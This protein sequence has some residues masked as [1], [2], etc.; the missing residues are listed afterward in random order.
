MYYS[1]DDQVSNLAVPLHSWS[2]EESRWGGQCLLFFWF[3]LDA[4]YLENRYVWIESKL[5]L[6]KCSVGGDLNVINWSV[7]LQERPCLE[8]WCQAGNSRNPSTMLT[9]I[10]MRRGKVWGRDWALSLGEAPCQDLCVS[11][12][13]HSC[14][15]KYM[16]LLL[17]LFFFFSTREEPKA[18]R[19]KFL[20]ITTELV[21]GRV[22]IQT[23]FTTPTAPAGEHY[24]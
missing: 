3:G 5:S 15:T 24:R 22:P 4:W 21:S 16:A 11:V 9:T 18:Q 6:V 2:G 20:V 13:P 19:D 12:K 23:P 8:C 7:V 14:R 1:L 10:K 17:L